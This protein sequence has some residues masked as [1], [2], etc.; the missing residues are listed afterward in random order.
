MFDRYQ[1]TS[2]FC[3]VV[4]RGCV[5]SLLMW[6]TALKKKILIIK[7]FGPGGCGSRFDS[8]F[9]CWSYFGE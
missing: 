7:D 2:E 6:R 1:N 8:H 3:T 4:G 5:F 9:V